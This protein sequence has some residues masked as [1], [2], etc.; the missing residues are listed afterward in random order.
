[1]TSIN[2]YCHINIETFNSRCLN[3]LC[4]L[5]D[6]LSTSFNCHSSP[7]VLLMLFVGAMAFPGDIHLIGHCVF[8][9]QQD[10]SCLFLL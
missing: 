2:V 6:Y 9:S 4:V 3:S 1:M 7:L 5:L 10:L 8:F